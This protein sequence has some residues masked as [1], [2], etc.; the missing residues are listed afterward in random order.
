MPEAVLMRRD[1]LAHYCI[2]VQ[3]LLDGSW[4][5]MLGNMQLAS[6]QRSDAQYITTLRGA[7][8]D[9]AALMGVLNLMYDLGMVLLS[10]EREDVSATI[11]ANV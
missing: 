3:G 2:R 10:V 9:Q 7:V 8:V 6:E 5:V 11:Q 1:E 4:A